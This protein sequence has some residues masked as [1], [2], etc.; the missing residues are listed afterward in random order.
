MYCEQTNYSRK[1]QKCMAL[2]L[3]FFA[4]VECLS[5]VVVVV[6]VL[7][8]YTRLGVIFYELVK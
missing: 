7:Y 6:V 8:I 1:N 4:D 2:K 3:P 5:T